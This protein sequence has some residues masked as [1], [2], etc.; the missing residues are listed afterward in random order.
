MKDGEFEGLLLGLLGYICVILTAI[1]FICST[2]N[3]NDLN[4]ATD[5]NVGSKISVGVMGLMITNA[6][7]EDDGHHCLDEKRGGAITA[8]LEVF[9]GKHIN[10]RAG[11]A[12]H[13]VRFYESY[14]RIKSEPR[15]DTHTRHLDVFSG[16]V[17]PGIILN[18]VEPYCVLGLSN[19]GHKIYGVGV[20]SK[21]PN[22]WSVDV[23][24]LKFYNEKKR[25]GTIGAGLRYS[26]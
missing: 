2:T 10:V 12:Y 23:E 4:S 1:L 7:S 5:I 3:A 8:D 13:H 16:T 6:H 14:R 26:F 11:V 25:F 20:S 9:S 17:K 21:V 24:V 15:E 19:L 18:N 22:G